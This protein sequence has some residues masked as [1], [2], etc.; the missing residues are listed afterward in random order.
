MAKTELV[1]PHDGVVLDRFVSVGDYLSEGD[2]VLEVVDLAELEVEIDIPGRYA[3][4]LDSEPAVTLTMDDLAE[5]RLDTT[6]TARVPAADER[7]RNF[8]G[9]VRIPQN[10]AHGALLLP[11]MFVR[12]ALALRA[13]K[14]VLLV[15]S[16]A[17]RTVQDDILVVR[18]LPGSDPPRAQVISVAILAVYEGVT[19][20]APLGDAELRPGDQVVMTGVER[21]FEGAVLL[22]PGASAGGHGE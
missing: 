19:A 21:A 20:I 1:A 15:P 22:L 8:I 16:D 11:G 17:V 9:L 2:P 3:V 4:D 12:V 10:D 7:S 6:L 18:V 14:G 5:F 13:R